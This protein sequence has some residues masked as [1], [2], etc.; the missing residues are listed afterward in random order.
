MSTIWTLTSIDTD[1]PTFVYI[2]LNEENL[3]SPF[4]AIA[5]ISKVVWNRHKLR[6]AADWVRHGIYPSNYVCRFHRNQEI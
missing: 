1:Q 5:R 3:L 2:S 6:I 4:R